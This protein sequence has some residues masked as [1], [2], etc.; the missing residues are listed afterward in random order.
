QSEVAIA[1]LADVV[2][3]V[4]M[5]GSGDAIQ[6]LKAGIMEIPDIVVLN[7]SDQPTAAAALRELGQALRLAEPGERPSLLETPGPSGEGVAG[8]WAALT[9]RRDTL[10]APGALAER[11]RASLE[12]EVLGLAAARA[13]RALEAAVADRPELQ[14]LLARVTARELDPLQAVT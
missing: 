2:A 1:T 14:A 11:R 8:R 13:A 6:A 5:P 4:L 7:K 3:L 12:R 10:E 9:A